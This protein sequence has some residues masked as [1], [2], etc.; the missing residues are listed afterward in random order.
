MRSKLSFS[1]TTR[2]VKLEPHRNRNW[3]E[4]RSVIDGVFAP[5]S[6]FMGDEAPVAQPLVDRV[7]QAREFFQT[8]SSEDALKNRSG[9]L[10][11]LELEKRARA[12]GVS[13]GV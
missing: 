12:H 2:I 8:V 7:A 10:A 1:I 3:L 11:Q 4:F 6:E 5:T 9:L 13:A